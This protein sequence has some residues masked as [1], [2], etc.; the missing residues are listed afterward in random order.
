MPT[1]EAW[2]AAVK[3]IVTILKPQ[4]WIQWVESDFKAI[5]RVVRWNPDSK[6]TALRRGFLELGDA[7]QLLHDVPEKLCGAFTDA[8]LQDV[9][10][11]C[12]ASNRVP[13]L[14]EVSTNV[15]IGASEGFLKHMRSDPEL[16]KRL[17]GTE[18]DDR[19]LIEDMYRE[20][21]GGAYSIYF[22]HAVMGRK[23]A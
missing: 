16:A 14:R 19:R 23:K 10:M 11:D 2:T 18:E 8:G 22:I 15:L 5:K 4:G 17:P 6:L 9:A 21:R 3:N 7:A 1:E 12:V 20:A 13:E